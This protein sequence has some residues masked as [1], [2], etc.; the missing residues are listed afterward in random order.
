VCEICRR[1]FATEVDHI[2]E[3]QDGGE[4]FDWDNLQSL[5]HDCHVKKSPQGARGGTR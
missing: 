5:C 1:E 3:L 4:E 2:K